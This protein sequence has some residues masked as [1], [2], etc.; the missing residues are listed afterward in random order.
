MNTP[1]YALV[2][3]A[4]AFAAAKHRDQRRKNLEASPYINHPIEVANTL[5]AIAKVDDPITLAAALLHDTIE[6]TETSPEELDREFGPEVRTVV[7]EVSDNKDVPSAERKRRQVEH[8]ALLSHRARLVKLADKIS[9]VSAVRATPPVGWSDQRRKD[10]AD[11]GKNVVDQMRG[12]N[13]ALEARFDEV[14][15]EVVLMP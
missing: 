1:D 11:W 10:Y 12:T 9:N 7:L 14:Y 15:A 4:A 8:A 2:L 5:A 6:D 13:A 3:R